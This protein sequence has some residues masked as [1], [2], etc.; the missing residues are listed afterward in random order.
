MIRKM[1][2]PF[3]SSE[4]TKTDPLLCTAVERDNVRV[5]TKRL[6]H[7][8]I[9]VGGVHRE[10]LLDCNFFILPLSFIHCTLAPSSSDLPKAQ[11]RN[12]NNSILC[13]NT[14][15]NVNSTVCR[16]II[17]KNKR[18]ILT[19]TIGIIICDIAH[20]HI[21]PTLRHSI[22]SCLLSRFASYTHNIY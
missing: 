14:R 8:Y 19:L 12:S 5:W 10:I 17:M 4:T 6:E 7:C 9:L 1:D 15:C 22:L 2:P 16:S 13:K 18:S 21:I 11:V 20:V 3:I